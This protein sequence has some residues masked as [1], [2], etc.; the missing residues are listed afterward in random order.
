M[1]R[2]VLIIGLIAGILGILACGLL[3]MKAFGMPAYEQIAGIV[4]KRS[5]IVLLLQIAGLVFSLIASKSPKLFGALIIIAG[6]SN[7]GTL[8]SS[9]HTDLPVSFLIGAVAGIMFIIAGIMSLVQKDKE[10]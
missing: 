5:A 9:I 4:L 2:A 7:F 3:I 10:E 6:L 1:K 8:D